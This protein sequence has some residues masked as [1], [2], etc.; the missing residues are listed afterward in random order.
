MSQNNTMKYETE[1]EKNKIRQI[2]LT[3]TTTHVI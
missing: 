3:T 2:V 1:K